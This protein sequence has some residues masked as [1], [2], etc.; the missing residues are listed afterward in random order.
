[1]P[2]DSNAKIFFHQQLAIQ[3]IKTTTT[4]PNSSAGGDDDENNEDG[5]N[6]KRKNNMG[7]VSNGLH[8]ESSM[9]N[10]DEANEENVNSKCALHIT[11]KYKVT[12]R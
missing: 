10:I 3:P 2:A 4:T 12:I 9:D 5:A 6:T 1:M 11:N 7:G 8:D